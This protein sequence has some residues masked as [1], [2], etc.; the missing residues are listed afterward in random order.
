[1]IRI[2]VIDDDISFCEKLKKQIIRINNSFEVDY[3]NNMDDFS[4]CAANYSIAV[5]DILLGGDSGIEK[6]A[7]LSEHFPMLNIIFV[8]VERDFFQ[9]VYMVNHAYFMVKP[10]SDKELKQAL[11]LCCRNLNEQ[12]LYIK[13]QSG[14]AVINL[15]NVTYFEGMLKKT[16][17]HYAD[18][19]EKILN[20]P[21]RTIENHLHNINFIRTHQSYIVNLRYATH[22]SKKGVMI[23][24]TEIPVSRRYTSSTV[25][26]I[27]HYISDNIL[28]SS[29]KNI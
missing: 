22:V 24:N 17:I 13:Q 19:T 28:Y 6:A 25:D 9:D 16:T 20:I 10:V 11:E 4:A 3:Y 5:I 23:Q 7:D 18:N 14:T 29:K 26:A 15:N 27:S 12:N 2:A 8:S 21:L 1:M